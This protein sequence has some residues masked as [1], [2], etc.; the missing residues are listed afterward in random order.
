MKNENEKIK[1]ILHPSPYKGQN[2]R[3]AVRTF[4]KVVTTSEK[5]L[6]TFQKAVTTSEKLLTTSEKAVRT[7]QP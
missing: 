1:K 6:T 4:Q 5:L 3:K 7:F 2:S